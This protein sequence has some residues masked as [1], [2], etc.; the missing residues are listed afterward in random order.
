M[1]LISGCLLGHNCKYNGGN[2]YNQDVIDFVSCHS[3]FSVCPEGISGLPTPR[4]P[5]E[6]VG[7]RVIDKE[8]KDVTDFF[9][10][11]AEVSLEEAMAEAARRG[12]RIEG[13]ILK[14]NSPSCGS[15]HIYD[16]SFSGT[17]IPGNGCFTK[18]LLDQDIKVISEKEIE[19]VKF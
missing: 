16:G 14:A 6:Y 15:G 4:P 12:E 18:L 17:L 3:C 7:D 11:G 19:N 8:G 5:A 2:N 9:V 10:K 13:A 1:Y